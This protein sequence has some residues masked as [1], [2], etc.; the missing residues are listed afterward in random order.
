MSFGVWP[1][2]G[3]SWVPERRN[4]MR[5]WFCSSFLSNLFFLE[6]NPVGAQLFLPPISANV[7]AN[8]SILMRGV[9]MGGCKQHMRSVAARTQG[10]DPDTGHQSLA[11]HTMGSSLLKE[12]RPAAGHRAREIPGVGVPRCS[13][14]VPSFPSTVLRCGKLSSF[15]L[16]LDFM[17]FY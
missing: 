9:T 7:N 12:A 16:S 6:K 17:Y 2:T 13:R 4:P 1:S 3:H 14:P 10:K 11:L 8:T 5:K 15:A